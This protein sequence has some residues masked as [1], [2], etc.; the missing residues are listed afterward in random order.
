MT[1]AQAVLLSVR[2]EGKVLGC[3]GIGYLF[4][5]FFNNPVD[6]VVGINVL[7][8]NI[9]LPCLVVPTL[10]SEITLKRLPV[11]L[12]MPLLA[13]IPT[14]IGFV[15]ALPLRLLL[16]HKYRAVFTLCCTFQY[17]L[18]LTMSL[19]CALPAKLLDR[20][21]SVQLAEAFM[22]LYNFSSLITFWSIAKP[23]AQSCK[24]RAGQDDASLMRMP[25]ATRIVTVEDKKASSNPVPAGTT[26][27]REGLADPHSENTAAAVGCGRECGSDDG[28]ETGANQAS[29][30]G[31]C[32]PKSNIVGEESVAPQGAQLLHSSPTSCPKQQQNRMLLKRLARLVFVS[33]KR[34][35]VFLQLVAL[36]IATVPQLRWLAEFP[37]G[38]L[39]LSG[40]K[41]IGNGAL[42]LQTVMFC[43]NLLV[44]RTRKGP[45]F[46]VFGENRRY[47]KKENSTAAA[48][49]YDTMECETREGSRSRSGFWV[50]VI[51]LTVV[52]L[53]VI[54]AFV[55]FFIRFLGLRFPMLREAELCLVVLFS[56]CLPPAIDKTLIDAMSMRM[57]Q[58]FIEAIH[59]MHICA[60]PTTLGWV[61]LYL[62]YLNQI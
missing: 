59:F 49:S 7:I 62:W 21:V 40:L 50:F 12:L 2:I 35:I 11:F 60:I 6:G 54:P 32:R 3:F 46:N 45:P 1:I 9:L 8:L 5:R 37:L 18:P 20:Q 42:P 34:P 36:L 25:A 55:F 26:E 39:I 28:D 53:A 56:S 19:L 57:A 44:Y 23:Y 22:F 43:C 27:C 41:I 14:L 33:L 31:P 47:N 15:L 29:V 52:R 58:W 10:V 4:S 24:R 61:S 17:G 16:S 30:L 38:V 48:D 13:L 51:L